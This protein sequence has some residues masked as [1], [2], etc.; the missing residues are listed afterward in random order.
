MWTDS[1]EALSNADK[2][3]FAKLVNR[4][5]SRTFITS[6]SYD[7]KDGVMKR[8]K[9]YSFI[10]RHME[11]FQS[12]LGYSGW[13]LA[14]DDDY[15][16]IALENSGDFN[17]VRLDRMTT[18]ILYV[19]RLIFEEEREKIS[20]SSGIATTVEQVVQKM[21]TFGI[22]DKRPPSGE[23]VSSFRQLSHYNIIE[24]ISG[25][26]DRPDTQIIILPSI[27]FIVRDTDIANLQQKISEVEKLA[28]ADMEESDGESD[29]ESDDEN[30]EKIYEGIDG[31]VDEADPEEGGDED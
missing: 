10:E 9:E 14:R 3:E 19:L 13:S 24:K 31:E 12:Y 20:L 8:S 11:L 1:H 2:E 4:L 6:R 23:L 28:V 29:G 7:Q 15:G 5:L 22:S 16:V 30:Y 25:S 27:L 17:R 26:W 18:L 21:I